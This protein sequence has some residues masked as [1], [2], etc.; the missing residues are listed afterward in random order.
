MEAPWAASK[1]TTTEGNDNPTIKDM[2][3]CGS[4]VGLKIPE[5]QL[6][7]KLI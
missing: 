1:R 6:L 7:K 2:D 4:R 3:I 5:R